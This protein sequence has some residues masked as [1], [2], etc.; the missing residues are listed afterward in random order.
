MFENIF[1]NLGWLFLILIMVACCVSVAAIMIIGIAYL[2]KMWR[3][4]DGK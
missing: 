3:E 2:V 1:F 4:K